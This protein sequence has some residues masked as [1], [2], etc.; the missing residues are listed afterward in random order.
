MRH[1][2]SSLAVLAAVLFSF[3]AHAGKSV[4]TLQFEDAKGV[5]FTQDAFGILSDGKADVS[6]ALQNALNKIKE[7]LEDLSF[8]Y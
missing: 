6:D 3:S 8:S 5:F 2:L 1:L 7:E 4:F